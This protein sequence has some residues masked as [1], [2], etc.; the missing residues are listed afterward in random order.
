MFA[1]R[2]GSHLYNLSVGASDEDYDIIFLGS[3]RRL[4]T[5]QLRPPRR[6]FEMHDSCGAGYGA[7]KS[8]EIEFTGTEF[9]LFVEVGQVWK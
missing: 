1:V 3:S 5:R 6:Q 9:G 8:G 4:A 2:S 7:D